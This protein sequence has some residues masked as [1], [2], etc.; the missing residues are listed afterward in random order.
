MRDKAEELRRRVE[1]RIRFLQDLGAGFVF[2]TEIK[3][4]APPRV[5]DKAG[6]IGPLEAAV[7]SC[8]LCPLSAGRTN[9][10][11]G[12][13]SY[14]APLMFVGEGPGADEDRLGR[15]FVGRAGQLLTKIIAAMQFTREEVYITNIVKCRPPENRTPFRSEAEAC[16]PY[17]LTQIRTIAPRVIVS[18]GKTATDFFVPS[19]AGM[20]DLRGTFQDFG[21]IKVMPTF[22]PSYVMRN[23][24]DP[25]IKRL[26]WED[27]KQVMAFLGK[28]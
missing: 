20:S 27:M 19:T 14:D 17:L 24:G 11:P 2:R 12:E 4:P 16:Q 9:A 6:V 3:P 7:R 10:V 28:K 8:T 18:L 23:E 15:P 1:D 22:H 5:Q 21:G 25:R 26:V 13:G